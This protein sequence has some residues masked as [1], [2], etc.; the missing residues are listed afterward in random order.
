MKKVKSENVSDE[1]RLDEIEEI[2]GQLVDFSTDM[3][4]EES[5]LF[6][7]RD[8]KSGSVYFKLNGDDWLLS[9][10]FNPEIQIDFNLS[11]TRN[12]QKVRKFILMAS[13]VIC[14][15]DEQFKD[16]LLQAINQES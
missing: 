3:E 10:M 8:N 16:I 15:N 13:S 9:Q 5:M 14:N 11:L 1:K 6:L 2:I 7:Y 4:K 12:F